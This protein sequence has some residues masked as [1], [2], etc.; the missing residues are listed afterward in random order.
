[1]S[2]RSG[3]C[4]GCKKRKIV[5]RMNYT[6]GKPEQGRYLVVRKHGPCGKGLAPLDIT[7]IPLLPLVKINAR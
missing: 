7:A 4:P 2:L 1:M 5:V 6:R 3:I